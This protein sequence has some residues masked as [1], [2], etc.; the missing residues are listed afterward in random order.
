MRGG[1][2]ESQGLTPGAYTATITI[3]SNA[4]NGPFTVPVE[5]DVVATG[6]R[7]SYYQGVVDNAI[8]QIGATIAPGELVAVRGEQF[9]LGAPVSAQTL[10]LGTSLGRRRCM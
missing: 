10:P 6:V 9:T 5:M 3:A 1:D 7:W 2:G 8:Y 4:K